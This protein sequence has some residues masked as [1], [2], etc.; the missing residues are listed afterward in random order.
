MATGFRSGLVRDDTT[1]ALAVT[2]GSGFSLPEN[3]KIT[4]TTNTPG[5][6]ISKTLDFRT[7]TEYDR[8][9]LAWYDEFNVLYA[10]AGWHRRDFNSGEYHNAWE[11]KTV[12]ADGVDMRTRISLGSGTDFTMVGFPSVT[13]VE[14]NQ[15]AAQNAV[16]FGYRLRTF[17]QDGSQN[18]VVAQL[19]A[20]SDATDN[21]VASLDVMPVV[22]GAAKGV[23]LQIF[24]NTNTGSGSN[25]VI[26]IKKGDGT[27]TN[28]M[29]LTARTGK[30]ELPLA[31]SGA[32]G[33][34]MGNDSVATLY[35]SAAST[36]QT[37]GNILTVGALGTKVKAGT[38]TDT[39][40]TTP[41]NGMIIVDSTANK[42]WVRIGGTWK[43]VVVA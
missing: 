12:A 37:D 29:V 16:D 4:F 9:W 23:T 20:R 18:G 38:P 21:I 6:G 24:R 10:A 32:T 11:V 22:A 26:A 28:A 40:V 30:L 13:Y 3:K 41:A 31:L 42:I 39:D 1:G 27:N 2:M 7:T 33:I 43:G 15:G 34:V 14:A 35:R 25:P 36:I 5:G 19:L 17:L 8:N